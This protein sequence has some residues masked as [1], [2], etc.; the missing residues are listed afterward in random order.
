MTGKNGGYK[1]DYEKVTK[2]KVTVPIILIVGLV[3][4]GV[5]FNGLTVDYLD[6]FFITSVAAEEQYKELS[7]QLTANTKLITGHIR[8]YELNENAKDTRRVTDQIY[9][10]EL[11][12]AANGENELAQ[13]RKRDLQAELARLGRVRACILR[14]NPDENCTAII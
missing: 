2:T 13:T 1:I 5:K 7:E 8:T 11:Y 9:N 4:F 6:D 3:V 12:V 14:N 10:L